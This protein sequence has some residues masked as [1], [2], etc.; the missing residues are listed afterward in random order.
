MLETLFWLFVLA[1]LAF[2]VIPFRLA[3]WLRESQFTRLDLAFII[4]VAVLV[5]LW[6]TA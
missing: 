1:V 3:R 2:G 6:V 4:V 5:L